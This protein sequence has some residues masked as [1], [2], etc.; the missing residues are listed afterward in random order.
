MAKRLIPGPEVCRRYNKVPSTIWRW[1]NDPKSRFPKPFYMNGR[2]YRDAD[3][4]DAYDRLLEAERVAR[5]GAP[6]A[7]ESSAA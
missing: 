2:K 1:D 5:F 3:E 4:L 6:V 7:D